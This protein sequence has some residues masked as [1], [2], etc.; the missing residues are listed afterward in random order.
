MYGHNQYINVQVWR[1]FFKIGIYAV[2]NANSGM[3]ETK[4]KVFGMMRCK[5][6]KRCAKYDKYDKLFNGIN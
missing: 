6:S 4:P 1:S 3:L 5:K 2:F